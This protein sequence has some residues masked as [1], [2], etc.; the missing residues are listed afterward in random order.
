MLHS[1]MLLQYLLAQIL[2]YL[3]TMSGVL[4]LSAVCVKNFHY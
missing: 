2:E 1:I 4:V 3:K